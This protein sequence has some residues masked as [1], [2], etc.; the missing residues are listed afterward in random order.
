MQ[1]ENE[2]YPYQIVLDSDDR[3]NKLTMWKWCVEQ[4]ERPRWDSPT[5]WTTVSESDMYI[6]KFKVE[7][8]QM[9]F[10]LRWA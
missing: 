3:K 2:L 7:E 10:L 8:H 4:W 6:F 9:M 5:S 1:V